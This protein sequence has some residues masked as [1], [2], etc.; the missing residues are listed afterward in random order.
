MLQLLRPVTSV[1]IA[2]EGTKIIVSF[3][4]KGTNEITNIAF[5]NRH[6]PERQEAEQFAFREASKREAAVER[7]WDGEPAQTYSPE[8]AKRE[9]DYMLAPEGERKKLKL[10]KQ[11]KQWCYKNGLRPAATAFPSREGYNWWTLKGKGHVWRVNCYAQFQ[12]GDTHEEFDR[13]ALC[14]ITE[15]TLPTTEAEFTHAVDWL[16]RCHA[17]LRQQRD[18]ENKH[19]G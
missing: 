12:C 4:Y 13:W 10:P 14:L 18:E 3:L 11:W 6:T 1:R 16:A 17:V 19:E 5:F 8:E 9:W 15:S 2:Y 7:L